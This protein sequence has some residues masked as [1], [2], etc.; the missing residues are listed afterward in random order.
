MA[1]GGQ[2]QIA[3]LG[4]RLLYLP[5]H[6]TG[7]HKSCFKKALSDKFCYVHVFVLTCVLCAHGCAQVRVCGGSRLRLRIF[8]HCSPCYSLRQRFSAE[9]STASAASQCAPH[10]C[11]SLL[12]TGVTENCNAH[13]TFPGPLGLMPAAFKTLRC[14]PSHSEY[15]REAEAEA[16]RE[17]RRETEIEREAETKSGRQEERCLAGC[18]CLGP[19]VSDTVDGTYGSVIKLPPFSWHTDWAVLLTDVLCQILCFS[20]LEV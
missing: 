13:Q 9:S 4:S 15:E 17:G 2:T 7:P 5:N 6:F 19:C 20:F 16:E 3:V 14:L 1:S 8:L 11:L 18:R 12:S 10:V